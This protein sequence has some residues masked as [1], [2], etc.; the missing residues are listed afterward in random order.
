[1]NQA[2]NQLLR[3]NTIV[4]NLPIKLVGEVIRGF[5]RGSKDL[6]CP[7]ANI[8]IEPY[9]ELLEQYPTGVYYGT[10]SFSDK[11]FSSDTFAIAMSIGWNPYFKNEKKTIEAHFIHNFGTDFYGKVINLDILGY[12]RQELNFN[13]LGNLPFF[14]HLF[15]HNNSPWQT[16]KR[17]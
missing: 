12:I 14:F 6:G 7:T 13:S 15:F 11:S 9:E 8:P 1:M 16:F 4:K 17:N 5:G 10:G 3:G 2:S